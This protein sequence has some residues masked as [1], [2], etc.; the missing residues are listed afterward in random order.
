[1]SYEVFIALISILLCQCVYAPLEMFPP[2]TQ[3]TQLSGTFKNTQKGWQLPK[4]FSYFRA[5]PEA[6]KQ[7]QQGI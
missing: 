1:V 6:Q 5:V 3:P 7:E 2:C 4:E